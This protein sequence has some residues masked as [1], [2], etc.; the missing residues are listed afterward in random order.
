MK[1]QYL[2]QQSDYRLLRFVPAKLRYEDKP[3]LT[4]KDMLELAEE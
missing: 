4:W 3:A 1:R 2:K